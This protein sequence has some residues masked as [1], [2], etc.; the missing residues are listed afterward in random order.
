MS[1]ICPMK[2]LSPE[3]VNMDV[4]WEKSVEEH[5]KAEEF[6]EQVN[7]EFKP[8]AELKKPDGDNF[9]RNVV[10]DRETEKAVLLVDNGSGL[11][12]WFP[13]KALKGNLSDSGSPQT[14][15]IHSWFVDKISWKPS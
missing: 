9:L 12:A 10:L 15:E 7:D 5:D 4:N 1:K 14:I 13:K 11:Q 2:V 6:S 8:I 3:N